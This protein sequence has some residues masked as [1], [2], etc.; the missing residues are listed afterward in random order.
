MS[1]ESL[2][3]DL[4]DVA[5]GAVT[6]RA[7][8]EAALD[9]LAQSIAF[10]A[11]FFDALNPRVPVRDGVWRGLDLSAVAASTRRWDQYAVDLAR[12]RDAALASGGVAVDIE[13]FSARERTRLEYFT[14]FARPLGIAACALTHLVL[15]GRV[16]AAIGLCRT[17]R[18]VRPFAK[19]DT[20]LLRAVAP[21]LAL[22]DAV[23]SAQAQPAP[24]AETRVICVDERLSTRQREIVAGVALGHTNAQIARALSLS[25]NTVRNALAEIFRVIGVAN[26]AELVRHAV[27]R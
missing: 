10:D 3:R 16:I 6:Q 11:A 4:A 12:W 19:T 15:R 27:L 21:L 1:L 22:G 9:R 5:V 13:V 14:Q 17:G 24:L 2:Q 8:R 26:R 23:H 20:D 25:P 7:F 18:S